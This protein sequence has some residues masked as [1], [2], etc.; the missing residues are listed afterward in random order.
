MFS[1]GKLSD[2]N[3]IERMQEGDEQMLITLYNRYYM[4]VKNFIL[5]NNGDKI[6]ADDVM[7]D[8]VI[9]VWKNVNTKSGFTLKSKLSTY[10]MAIA[11]N[12]WYKELKKRTRF[13]RVDETLHL[14]QG[15]E[16]MRLDMDKGII[17]SIIDEMDDTC[18]KLLLYFYFDGLS[19]K[20]IA[21][22]LNFAN[23]NTVK[24]KK[25]QCFKKLQSKVRN[26]FSKEDLI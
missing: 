4:M 1:F 12:I 20:I 11:K 21:D 8:C 9:A 17:H 2:E 18:R 25:Y 16:N 6:A 14:D 15:E 23:T 5:K 3:I 22:K 19:T 7:Q 13:K 24:S 26:R 10:I